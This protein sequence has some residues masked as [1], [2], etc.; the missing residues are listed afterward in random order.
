[1]LR[2]TFGGVYASWN[3]NTMVW[4]SDNNDIQNLLQ[5]RFEN[6]VEGT[7]TLSGF[8]RVHGFSDIVYED[9]LKVFGSQV[10]LV[11]IEEEKHPEE[12]AGLDY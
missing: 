4:K 8:W 12:V 2:I 10:V 5:L 6:E 9:L 1:M 11:E 3:P 7:L